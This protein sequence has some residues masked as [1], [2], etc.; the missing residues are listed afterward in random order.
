MSPYKMSKIEEALRVVLAFNDAFNC[1][2]VP[3]M[4]L[5]MS[6]DCV[7]ENTHPAP[8]GTVYQG[9]EAVTAFWQDFFRQSPQAHIAIEEIFHM[10]ERCIM[11]WKYTWMDEQGQK[12]HVRGVDVFRVRDGLIAEKL[13]YVKG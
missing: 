9:K 2:D 5:R 8:D 13:S 4:M 12:G 6:E 3:D 11:R 1:H 7:F 10:G